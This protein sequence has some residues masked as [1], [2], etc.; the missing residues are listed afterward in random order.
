MIPLFKIHTPPDMGK[1]L[2]SVFDSGFLT[3]GYWSDK[4]EDLFSSYV[5]N[6]NTCLL[7]SCTSALAI[8]SHVIGIKPGDEVITTAMTCMATNEP[9][10]NDGAKLVFADVCKDTGN[11]SVDS[12]IK[13]ITSK[14]KCIVVVHWAGQP[15]EIKRLYEYASKK[16]IKIVSDA[17]HAL[18]AY[19]YDSKIGDCKYS[20]FT[21]F[22]FQAI[23]HLTTADGGAISCKTTE[24]AE[25]IRKIRWFGLDRKFSER[26]GRSR[27]DQDITES[28][29]KM[30]M[31]NLNAAIGVAQ[32]DYIE[33]IIGAHVKN[34]KYYDEHIA[35]PKIKKMKQEKHS[36]SAYWIYSVLVEDKALFQKYCKSH[37][38]GC[39][40]VH[41]RN[42]NYTIFKEFKSKDTVNLD[43]FSERLVN[44]PVGWWISEKERTFIVDCLN[45]Y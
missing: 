23:K 1:K 6:K 26:T 38:I 17:A 39:D 11:I 25:R 34:G 15:V 42:D 43:Y 28:G 12:I 13:K 19:H 3:E 27:W 36:K 18:G 44:I 32:M 24:D 21:C 8:A 2:Q 29:F 35:N 31:N 45:A 20:D 37:G 16:G 7:N 41:V 5:Q 4:F 9:F 30:H 40:V 33:D 14:T 10:F 22:S